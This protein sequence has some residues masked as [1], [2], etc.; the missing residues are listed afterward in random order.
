MAKLPVYNGSK[1]S[2]KGKQ[3]QATLSDLGIATFPRGG[4]YIKSHRTGEQKL[5]L[6][7]LPKMEANEFYDGEGYD[8]FIPA[9][10]VEVHIHTGQ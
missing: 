2:W 7:N 5:F 8:Y 9:G 6:P 1:F 3:G 10:E 4:F